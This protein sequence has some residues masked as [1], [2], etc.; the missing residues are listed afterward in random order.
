MQ[1]KSLSSFCVLA[2]N[3]PGSVNKNFDPPAVLRHFMQ[4]LNQVG[5]ILQMICQPGS[6]A[7]V[8]HRC[9]NLGK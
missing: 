5:Q 7:R 6:A 1:P 3:T 8:V 4:A 2:D 9:L